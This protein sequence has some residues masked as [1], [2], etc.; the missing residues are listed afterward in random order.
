M[1]R[2]GEPKVLLREGGDAAAKCA[3]H[4]ICLTSRN[5]YRNEG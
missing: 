5:V 3:G 4:G 2:E 1:G